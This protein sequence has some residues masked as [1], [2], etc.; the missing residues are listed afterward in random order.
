MSCKQYRNDLMSW[1]DRE[2]SPQRSKE[3]ELWFASCS[4]ERKCTTCQTKMA[5]YQAIKDAMSSLPYSELPSHVHYRI[6]DKL[7]QAEISRAKKVA[8]YRWQAVPVAMAIILSIY[9]GSLV[10][11]KTLNNT[12]ADSTV[13]TEL[14]SFGESSLAEVFLTEGVTP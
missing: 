1:M 6:M 12:S 11:S 7:K 8:G 3:L 9:F 4:A 2:L 10:S 13:S 14:Y 5:E